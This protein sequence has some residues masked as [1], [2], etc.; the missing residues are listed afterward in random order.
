MY[1]T[2][3]RY[4]QYGTRVLGTGYCRVLPPPPPL[5]ASLANLS[6]ALEQGLGL[7]ETSQSLF[8]HRECFVYRVGASHSSRGLRAADFLPSLAEPLATCTAELR[9]V[10][11]VAS[12]A[13]YDNKKKSAGTRVA[14]AKSVDI[15]LSANDEDAKSKTVF[16]IT[17]VLDSSRYFRV[18]V[19]DPRSDR[20]ASLGIGFREKEAAYAFT[21]ALQDFARS[22]KQGREAAAFEEAGG[23][24]AAS[25]GQGLDLAFKSGDKISISIKTK[26]KKRT[27][28]KKKKKKKDDDDSFGNFGGGDVDDSGGDLGED[29]FGDFV[30]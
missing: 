1:S 22:V 8:T 7:E 24:A 15:V 3:P 11:G 26:K 17:P 18:S 25:E 23:L 19:K 20:V 4:I 12:L 6:A 5:M 16:Y 10:A 28:K 9:S 2:V 14:L 30:S 27:K 13:L 21:A 29:D